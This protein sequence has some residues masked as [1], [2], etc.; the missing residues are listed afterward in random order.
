MPGLRLKQLVLLTGAV[1]FSLVAVTNVVDLTSVIGRFHWTFLNSGNAGYIA[2]VTK[3]YN[4]PAWF[5]TAAVVLAALAEGVGAYLFS[6]AL[7]RFRGSGTG[8]REAWLALTWNIAV[9]LTFII[10]TEFFVAYQ[11]EGPFRELLAIGLLMALVIAV[12]PDSPAA[13]SVP[14]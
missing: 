10:G 2:S 4:F 3:A 8:A 6:R 13:P 7:V 14:D 1:Y 11:S 12:V 9:W 5:A